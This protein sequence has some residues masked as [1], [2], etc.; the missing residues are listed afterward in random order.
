MSQLISVQ[1]PEE[2]I[3][4]IVEMANFISTYTLSVNMK[5]LCP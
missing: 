4:Q 2:M 5:E 1:T 3:Q